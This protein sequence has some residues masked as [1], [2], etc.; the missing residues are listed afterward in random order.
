MWSNGFVFYVFQFC[1][2]LV[3][4]VFFDLQC[5]DWLH[6]RTPTLATLVLVTS[7]AASLVCGSLL[8]LLQCQRELAH[9]ATLTQMFWREQVQFCLF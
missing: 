8:F 7:V 5:L 4:N 3:L 9:T 2:E 6:S 1:S